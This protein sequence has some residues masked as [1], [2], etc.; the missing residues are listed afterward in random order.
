MEF[1]EDKFTV[2]NIRDYREITN[3]AVNAEIDYIYIW[4]NPNDVWD[5]EQ[6]DVT[7]EDDEFLI[8][9]V[10]ETVDQGRY[11]AIKSEKIKNLLDENIIESIK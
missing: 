11:V 5:Y 10:N 8:Q 7:V 3:H 9:E 6:I 2:H 4:S 1:N